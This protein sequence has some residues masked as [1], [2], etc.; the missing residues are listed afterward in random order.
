MINAVALNTIFSLDSLDRRANRELQ[1]SLENAVWT[2]YQDHRV[3]LVQRAIL[4][5][6]ATEVCLV[7][8]DRQDSVDRLE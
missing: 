8:R 4:A 3:F 2:D 5:R 1:E 6:R 7:C